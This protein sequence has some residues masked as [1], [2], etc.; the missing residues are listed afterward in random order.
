LLLEGGGRL[1]DRDSTDR[2]EL[3]ADRPDRAGDEDRLAGDLASLPGEL[4]G[5][6]VDVADPAVEPV[7]GELDPVG[8]EGVGLDQLRAGR[9][10]R[11]VN[12]LDDFG[13]GQVELVEGALEAHPAC[14]ELG[15]HGAVPE[16]RAAREPLKE[17]IDA[18]GGGFRRLGHGAQ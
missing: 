12:F 2:R 10:V 3:L 9:N 5:S 4:D 14:V 13:L 15:S 16:E 7:A 11:P 1:G 17:R 18:R 8:A 6:E